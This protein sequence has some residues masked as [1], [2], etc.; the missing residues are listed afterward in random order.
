MSLLWKVLYLRTVSLMIM[1]RLLQLQTIASLQVD[2]FPAI[3]KTNDRKLNATSFFQVLKEKLHRRYFSTY[4]FGKA[5]SQVFNR[6]IGKS[7]L[8]FPNNSVLASF[9]SWVAVRGRLGGRVIFHE[10]LSASRGA[11]LTFL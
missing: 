3:K 6:L 9:A 7:I 1:K 10:A 8:E 2:G 5:A 11:R 4:Y